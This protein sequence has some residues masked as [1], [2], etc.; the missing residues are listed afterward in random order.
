MRRIGISQRV[1]TYPDRDERRDALDQRWVDLLWQCGILAIPLPSLCPDNTACFNLLA[2]DGFILSGGN[3]IGQA[4]ERDAL[5]TDTLT[6]AAQQSLPVLAVCR[7]MQFMN[8]HAGGHLRRIEGHV[9]QPH[10]ITG[11]FAEK[12][13][14]KQVNSYHELGMTDADMA[15]DLEATAHS[16]D[17]FVE[18]CVHRILP[19]C[20]IMWHPERNTP[21]DPRDIRMIQSHFRV[22]L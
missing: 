5:E 14:L 12:Y 9:A 11:P 16:T 15:P 3:D 20:G 18:A 19:W 8:H 10:T 21:Y 6:Y 13:G 1:D 4:P 2:L 17:D 7:G 22:T